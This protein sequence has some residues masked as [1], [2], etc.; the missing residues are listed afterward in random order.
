MM[1]YISDAYGTD[2]M[3]L[4]RIE[5]FAAAAAAGSFTVTGER[6][7]LSQSAVSQQIRLLEEE[8]GEALFVRGHRRVKLTYSG[9][10]LLPAANELMAAWSRFQETAKPDKGQLRGRIVVGTSAAAAAYLWGA[11]YRDFGFS[12]PDVE[13]DLKTVTAT[14]TSLDYIQS[15]E[16]DFA[17]VPLPVALR[18]TDAIVLGMQE[19]LLCAVPGHPL[20]RKKTVSRG[21]LIG[22]RFVL[23]EKSMAIRWLADQFFQALELKPRIVMESNDTHLIKVMVEYGYGIG[24]LPDWSV[25]KEIK[26]RRI[27]V[28]RTAGIR[29]RQKMGLIFRPRSLSRVGRAFVAF[30]QSHSHLVPSIAT[31]SRSSGKPPRRDHDQRRKQDQEQ[32][33]D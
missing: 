18:G 26:E 7:H 24:F 20:A 11:I 12:H 22:Q 28:L 25:Q 17:F 8:V 27:V 31:K 9:E 5:I 21:D 2:G 14:D 29:L 3:D 10:Q 30:C 15:G 4:R 33:D 13:M 1:Q 32:E 16:L 6:L 23:Y 19:G